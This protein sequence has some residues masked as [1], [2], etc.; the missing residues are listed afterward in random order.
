MAFT[1]IEHAIAAVGRGEFVVV[2]DDAD[3]ENEGDLIMAAEKMTPET[4]A[5]MVRHTSG[6]ICMPM[7]GE[8]LDELQLPLM[9]ARQHRGP[10]HRVHDLGRRQ[11]TGPPPASPPPTA[12][13]R[14][15]R[16]ST[17]RPAPTT[18]PGPATSSRCATARA[19]CSSAPGTPRPRSTSRGWRG[20]IRPGVLAEIVNDDGT[21]ARLP[22]LERF[23][24]EH[25]LLLISI[26]DLIRYRRHREKLVRRVVRGAHPDEVRRLHRVRVRVAARRHRAPGVRAGRGRR[27]SPNVLVRVHSRVPHRRRVRIA[28][29]RLRRAARLG[30]RAGRRRRARASSC[31]C[32]ATRA[33]ASGSATSCAPTPSRTRAATPSRPTSSSGSRPTAASTASARRSSSTSGSRTMRLMTNNPA[34]YGGLEGYGLEIVERVPLRA[35][36]HRREHRLPA[37][38]SRRSSA[39]CSTSRTKA[40]GW[41][42]R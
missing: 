34:K 21:M 36:A 7:E 19:A 38:R 27:A 15:T 9:V 28:A 16:S 11:G 13:R 1:E 8:R 10:A 31:T 22:E 37:Q 33:G 18:S 41:M 2:V 25:G 40:S 20:C 5:F 14:S 42:S 24:A 26:A 3:R 23:A 29:L 4:M 39:I 12:P 32:A 30:A 17:P 35:G 6:V